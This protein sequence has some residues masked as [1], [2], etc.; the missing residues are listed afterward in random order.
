MFSFDILP[1]DFKFKCVDFPY[2]Y[3]GTFLFLISLYKYKYSFKSY[4]IVF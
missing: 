1:W 3:I 2:G 4:L